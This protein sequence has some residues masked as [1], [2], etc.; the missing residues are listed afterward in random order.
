MIGKDHLK[1]VGILLLCLFLVP[2]AVLLAGRDVMSRYDG[3]IRDHVL[4]EKRVSA[5]AYDNHHLGY[6]EFC[7]N[8]Q[9]GAG[10]QGATDVNV[11]AIC[12]KADVLR[13]V[14]TAC[15]ATAALGVLLFTLILGGKFI[16]G[17]DRARMSLIFGPMVRAVMILLALSTL[18]QVALL[19]L[20]TYAVGVMGPQS[21]PLRAMI[22]L[23]SV[24]VGA[25]V[26][27]GI[28]VRSAFSL[29]KAE[30]MRVRGVRLARADSPLLF[31]LVEAIANKLEASPPD[32]VVVG[33][34]PN[35]FVTAN[36]VLVPVASEVLRGRTLFLSLGLMRLFTQS[37]LAAVVGH[38]LGHFR[39]QDVAYSMKFAPTYSRLGR[40]LGTLSQ[41]TGNASDYGRIP[42]IVA[43]S[44]CLMEF[45]SAERTVGRDRELLA[46]KAGVEAADAKS[47]AVAL[48]KVSLF[49][50]RWAEAARLQIDALS[51]G[52]VITALSVIYADG[53]KAIV[54]MLDWAAAAGELGKSTQPHPVDTHPSLL[55]RLQNLNTSFNDVG[56]ADCMPPELSAANLLGKLDETE[57]Q[58]SRLEAAWLVGIGAASVPEVSAV[59]PV[60]G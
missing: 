38:E 41:G 53:C 44:M 51:Q 42:A 50:P 57:V 33:L 25:L 22:L 10:T 3:Q 4:D 12:S 36:D 31:T 1:S 13:L 52:R 15:I 40:A 30:P 60:T 6:F 19:V 27:C 23:A 18:G 48:V 34:E 39:G 7:D 17:T 2:I 20:G 54:G 24:S 8:A 56:V 45:A 43:L 47:L 46:D 9:E 28:L 35:F 26:A 21:Y 55:V 58:L 29:F 32:N 59:L 49:A 14:Q 11:E 16:A 5:E 37:E